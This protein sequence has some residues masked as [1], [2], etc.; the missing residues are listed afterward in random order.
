MIPT[1]IF[2]GNGR[3]DSL[4]AFLLLLSSAVLAQESQETDE[5]V[6]YPA[7]IEF[8]VVFPRNDTYAPADVFPIIFALRN[9]K[10]AAAFRPLMSWYLEKKGED[11]DEVLEEDHTDMVGPRGASEPVGSLG[12]HGMSNIWHMAPTNITSDPFYLVYWT[13]K[14][15]GPSA[16]GQYMLWSDF[17]TFNC[18]DEWSWGHSDFA[19]LSTRIFFTIEKGAKAPDLVLCVEIEVS[20]PTLHGHPPLHNTTSKQTS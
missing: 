16:E 4:T 1:G 17:E 20:V 9:P 8:D 2:S 7:T 15:K 5:I 18:T 13:D 12:W 19:H 11:R 10:A 3:F 14:L 6:Q